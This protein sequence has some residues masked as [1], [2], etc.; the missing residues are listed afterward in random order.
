MSLSSQWTWQYKLSTTDNGDNN[1]GVRYF[2]KDYVYVF[3][4]VKRYVDI[5]RVLLPTFFSQTITKAG[6][7]TF[8]DV[9]V[10]NQWLFRYN[11]HVF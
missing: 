7:S 10:L 2:K 1:W 3:V 4:Q 9:F 6:A 5:T 8:C 11:D